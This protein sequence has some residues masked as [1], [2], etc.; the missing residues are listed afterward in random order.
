MSQ[1]AEELK[2]ELTALRNGITSCEARLAELER[3]EGGGGGGTAGVTSFRGLTGAVTATSLDTTKLAINNVGNDVQFN[4]SALAKTTD[5][6]AAN[7]G[8]LVSVDGVSNPGGNVDFIAGTGI[9]IL[10]N[11]GANTVTFSNT[12]VTSVNGSTG[13]VTGIATTA[14][15]GDYV[16]VSPSLAQNDAAVSLNSNN[17][18]KPTAFLNHNGA[19]GG[20]ALQLYSASG[21]AL[22][23][24]SGST[25]PAIVA[26]N[27]NGGSG[28]IA[29]SNFVA[30]SAESTYA[31]GEA[32]FAINNSANANSIGLRAYSA[33]GKIAVFQNGT[34]ANVAEILQS[35]RID[36]DDCFSIL[37]VKT[38]MRRQVAPL[39][40]SGNVPGDRITDTAGTRNIDFEWD[41]TNSRWLSVG[42]IPI[43]Y[44][45]AIG[46]A[47]PL[48]TSGTII[49]SQAG[50]EMDYRLFFIEYL[51]RFV[52][53]TTLNSTNYWNLEFIVQNS[54]GTNTTLGTLSTWAVGR[55]AGTSYRDRLTLNTAMASVNDVFE[56]SIN[57]VKVGSPGGLRYRPGVLK[58]RLIGN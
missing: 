49:A 56:L 39:P 13:A 3:Q 30:I 33:G 25:N 31:T 27:T 35:G 26:T 47:F 7:A 51:T 45:F 1:A 41:G 48:T 58:A 18:A 29:V 43:S 50:F 14:Q 23:A 36:T 37:G 46:V 52:V 57:A 20:D 32:F 54:A 38:A 42:I 44:S 17:D 28:V 16:Q 6:T 11:D 5:I 24:Q 15:L 53:D 40:T 22:S 4:T 21:N 2:R 8:A 9:G 12:G 10:P 34:S 19:G 55:T